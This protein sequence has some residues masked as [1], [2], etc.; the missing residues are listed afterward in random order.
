MARD[1]QSRI[2]L[3]GTLVARTPLHVGGLGEDVETDLPLARDGADR[4]YVPGT[5]L[6]GALRQWCT[7]RFDATLV[8]S[9]WGFQEGD[10]GHAS[11]V[12]VLDAVIENADSVVV[13]IRDGVGIDRGRG[14]AAEHIKYDRA[15]LPRGTRLPL[16]LEF[17]V[18]RDRDRKQLLGMVAA[19]RD[20]LATGGL[21]LGASKTRG[22]GRVEL[23]DARITEQVFS[24]RE[25]IFKLLKSGGDGTPVS[26]EELTEARDAFPPPE[27]PQFEIMIDWRPAGPLMVKAGF[28]GIAVDM[29]PL[30]SG[31]GGG[32]ALVLP[33]SS[34]KGAFRSQGE[35]IVRTVLDRDLSNQSDP[36]KKFLHDLELPLIDE[37]FGLR[38]LSE[39]DMKKRTANIPES[40]PLPGLGALGID[41][42]YGTHQIAAAQWQE[43]VSAQTDQDLR[44]GLN[45]AFLQPWQEAYHV[46]VDR[47]TGGAAEGFLYTV[48]EP[49]RAEWEPIRLTVDL[50]R[51]AEPH[52]LPAVALLLLILRDLVQA[53]VPFGFATHRGMGAVKVSSITIDLRGTDDVL[54]ALGGTIYEKGQPTGVLTIARGALNQSWQA[55]IELARRNGGAA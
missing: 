32:L 35:R 34:V 40:T 51:L 26:Q 52:R 42:C 41:D 37:L 28:D 24:T 30:V 4:L 15:V 44:V 12:L 3:Q 18:C 7:A 39:E 53:R 54:A 21:R 36:K 1:I 25:G 23:L 46:A 13:E 45:R 2:I 20:A 27:S 50:G 9:V 11:H 33:G 29:L 47:W 22:L 55:W 38:G 16:R 8:E 43:I 31:V 17:E 6:A 10:K 14:A 19:L 48:L 49:H 5:S